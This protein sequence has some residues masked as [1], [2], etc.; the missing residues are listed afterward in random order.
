VKP[1]HPLFEPRLYRQD[2]ELLRRLGFDPER[3]LESHEDNVLGTYEH[4]YDGKPEVAYRVTVSVYPMP[5]QFWT[6]D[7]EPETTDGKPCRVSTG[8][9]SLID[10]WP[11]IELLA[12]GMITVKP[13]PDKCVDE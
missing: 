12:S 13:L 2:H 8:S 3:K 1:A 9:G 7:I 11:T 4:H 5:A 6:F 10:Y